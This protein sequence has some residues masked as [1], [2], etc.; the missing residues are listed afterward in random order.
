M[1]LEE[2]EKRL[3][4]S[5]PPDFKSKKSRKKGR[6]SGGEKEVIFNDWPIKEAE[7]APTTFKWLR[8]FLVGIVAVA[9]VVVSAA[10]LIIKNFLSAPRDVTIEILA[11]EEVYRGVPFEI[12]FQ[13]QNGS[14]ALLSEANLSVGLGEGLINLGAAN[15]N[16]FNESI[17]DLGGGSLKRVIKFWLLAMRQLPNKLRLL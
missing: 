13:I 3:Y 15:K 12:T 16:F 5:T 6:L 9:I 1:S 17:G 4:R 8:F 11:P 10:A 14:D 7:P 2:L